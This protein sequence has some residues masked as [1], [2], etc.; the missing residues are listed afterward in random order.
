MHVL[1]SAFH[2]KFEFLAEDSL[3]KFRGRNR[4]SCGDDVGD[5]DYEWYS[6]QPASLLYGAREDEYNNPKLTLATHY[7]WHDVEVFVAL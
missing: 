3:T 6:Q 1:S 2:H 5:G 4:Q 7:V